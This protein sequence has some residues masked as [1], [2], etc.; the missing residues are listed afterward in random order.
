MIS[1]LN[2]RFSNIKKLLFPRWDLNREW[3]ITNSNEKIYKIVNI[4]KNNFLGFCDKKS[5][6]IYLNLNED[7]W[8]IDLL[9]VHEICHTFR[10]CGNH[11]ELW[12]GKMKSVAERCDQIENF[13]LADQIR[14]ELENYER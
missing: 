5:K 12:K 2:I 4:L 3:E 6:T 14:H 13:Q 11:G 10:N 9:I 1:D 7:D 8:M